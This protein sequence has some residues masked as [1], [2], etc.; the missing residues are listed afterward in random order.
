MAKLL[1][2][3][4]HQS[5]SAAAMHVYGIDAVLQESRI[6]Q[7]YT[8]SFIGTMTEGTSEVQRIVMDRH[9]GARCL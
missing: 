3:E 9:I 2:S 7:H 6:H 4:M 5:I 8:G 1:A